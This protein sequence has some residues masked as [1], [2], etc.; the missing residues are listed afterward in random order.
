MHVAN[1]PTHSLPYS[2]HRIRSIDDSNDTDVEIK[3]KNIEPIIK[4]QK[5]K[6]NFVFQPT[7]E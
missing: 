1:A 2:V 5:F 7:N 4:E 6:N 3:Y